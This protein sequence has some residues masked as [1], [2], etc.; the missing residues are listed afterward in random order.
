MSVERE[1]ATLATKVENISVRAEED[2]TVLYEIRDLSKGT[3]IKM[4]G[5]EKGFADGAAKFA[6]H[7]RKF[8]I[9]THELEKVKERVTDLETF[10]AEHKGKGGLLNWLLGTLIALGSLAMLAW[11]ALKM[12]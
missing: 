5:V 3:N 2:R 7:D 11:T 8:D 10:R 6:E 12:H 1:I 9:Q 4:E